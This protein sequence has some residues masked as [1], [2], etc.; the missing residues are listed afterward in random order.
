MNGLHVRVLLQLNLLHDLP[1]NNLLH[2]NSLHYRIRLDGLNR[3]VLNDRLRDDRLNLH[4]RNVLNELLLN[5]RLN[6]ELLLNNRSHAYLLN[7]SRRATSRRETLSLNDLLPAPACFRLGDAGDRK[8]RERCGDKQERANA[9]QIRET[10]DKTSCDE[11]R[12]NGNSEFYFCGAAIFSTPF[13]VSSQCMIRP[14]SSSVS[15]PFF[16]MR[17]EKTLRA[18]FKS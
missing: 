3:L 2:L 15:L 14:T 7:E 11:K 6:D 9:E 5:D 17:P 1:L 13:C 18:M 8:H 12:A 16:G 4:L 10:H